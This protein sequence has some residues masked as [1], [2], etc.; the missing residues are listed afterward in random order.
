MTDDT[1]FYAPNPRL[2]E[3]SSYE[4]AMSAWDECSVLIRAAPKSDGG[5]AVV[6]YPQL[7]PGYVYP[8]FNL[9]TEVCLASFGQVAHARLWAR[10]RGYTATEIR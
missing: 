1:E 8:E 4:E 2:T 7:G 6:V 3:I 5:V 10:G 9:R